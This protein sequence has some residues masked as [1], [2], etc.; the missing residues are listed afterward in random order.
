MIAPMLRALPLA[1]LTLAACNQTSDST[2][3]ET[4][5][6]ALNQS[7]AMGTT[8]QE[9]VGGTEMSAADGVASTAP[10]G[11]TGQYGNFSAAVGGGDATANTTV[12]GSAG[13]MDGASTTGQAGTSG[14]ESASGTA[15]SASP[16]Q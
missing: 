6:A 8:T 15:K 7:A 13:A 1:L 9:S 3:P 12:G 2:S 11:T 14:V 10:A 4:G 5:D 16:Q